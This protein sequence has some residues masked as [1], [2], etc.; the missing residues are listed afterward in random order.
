M[1]IKKKDLNF[2]SFFMYKF[3]LSLDFSIEN[4]NVNINC[5]GYIENEYNLGGKDERLL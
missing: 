3:F 2:K 1:K 5:Y 4:F